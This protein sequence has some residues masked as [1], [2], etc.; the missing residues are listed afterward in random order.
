MARNL[1]AHAPWRPMG[2]MPMG[3][4]EAH[5]AHRDP[6][7]METLKAAVKRYIVRIRTVGKGRS[8]EILLVL[9]R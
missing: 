3:T 1:G 7:L 8:K 6:C 2:H 4:H 5:G 9:I